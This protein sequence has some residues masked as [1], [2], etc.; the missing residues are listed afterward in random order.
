MPK[1]IQL[2]YLIQPKV[3]NQ[4][5]VGL[6]VLIPEFLKDPFVRLILERFLRFEM[7]LINGVRGMILPMPP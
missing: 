4:K 2:Y 3:N 6:D 1:S 7:W 5:S